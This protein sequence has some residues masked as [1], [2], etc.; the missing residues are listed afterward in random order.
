MTVALKAAWR[1]TFRSLFSPCRTL[2][3]LSPG[4]GLSQA[5]VATKPAQKGDAHEG[6][7]PRAAPTGSHK[8]GTFYAP[9]SI[10]TDSSGNIYTTETY[11]GARVQKFINKGIR[12]VTTRER[13]PTW[14]ASEL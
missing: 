10:A 8:P 3:E 2:G 9:H 6:A 13:A 4:N 5:R 7:R 1:L 14:P 12:A 11:E